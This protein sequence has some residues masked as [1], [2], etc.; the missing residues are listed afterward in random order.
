MNPRANRPHERKRTTAMITD[1][2]HLDHMA[3]KTMTNYTEVASSRKASAAVLDVLIANGTAMDNTWCRREIAANPNLSLEAFE[4]LSHD[5]NED[6]LWNL[7][8][9]PNCPA[10]ILG[11]IVELGM[12]GYSIQSIG[13]NPSLDASAQ[14]RLVEINEDD[15]WVYKALAQNPNLD[16]ELQSVIADLQDSYASRELARRR[17]L[18]LE[19]QMTLAEHESTWVRQPLAENSSV[20]PIVLEFLSR[21]EDGFVRK[22]VANNQ[23][24]IRETLVALSQDDNKFVMRAAKKNRNI[25][26]K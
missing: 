9:N 3:F 25:A 12:K 20:D 1:Q 4:T 26:A 6:V 16:P 15:K 14:A 2:D 8:G 23:T 19:I 13:S 18:L 5:H 21:D 22:A 17:D 24:T 10:E 7:G 11:R